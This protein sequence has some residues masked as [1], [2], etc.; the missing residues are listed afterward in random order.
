MEDSSV[1]LDPWNDFP[2]I[3]FHFSLPFNVA[4]RARATSRLGLLDGNFKNE[5]QQ[6]GEMKNIK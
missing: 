4:P 6:H 3:I 2:F 1:I 5:E